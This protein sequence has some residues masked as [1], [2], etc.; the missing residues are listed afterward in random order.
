MQS[1]FNVNKHQNRKQPLAEK[2]GVSISTMQPQIKIQRSNQP[3]Q[4][5]E[6]SGAANQNAAFN[7]KA[8]PEQPE[9]DKNSYSNTVR[10]QS[11]GRNLHLNI[12]TPST[13]NESKSKGDASS[14]VSDVSDKTEQDGFIYPRRQRRFKKRLGKAQPPAEG[15]FAGGNR[16]SEEIRNKLKQEINEN[17]ERNISKSQQNKENPEQ[18]WQLIKTSLLGPSK[19]ELTTNK[20]KK[21]DWMT[22][23]L[24]ELMNEK[25]KYKAKNNTCF[26][27]L[28]SKIR[29]KIREAKETYFSERCNEI[30]EYYVL[31]QER[32]EKEATIKKNIKQIP[33]YESVPNFNPD[34]V[35][36]QFLACC[37]S[38]AKICNASPQ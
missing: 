28:Q 7:Q 17:L 15:N 25:R 10:K 16:K 4:N 29:R 21:E 2:H 27:Q 18:Q 9:K 36:L 26:K 31:K 24:L 19:K 13:Q 35:A 12:P 32:N 1:D 37:I 22:D 6:A 20:D 33:T 11:E 38:H 3:N 8:G 5:A 23:E 14:A 34:A 30:E